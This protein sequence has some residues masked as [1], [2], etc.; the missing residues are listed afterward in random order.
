[1]QQ[2]WRPNSQVMARK[3]R[4]ASNLNRKGIAMKRF[5]MCSVVLFTCTSMLL[6]L[7]GCPFGQ[8]SKVA[9]LISAQMMPSETAAKAQAGHIGLE[10]IDSLI[11][12]VTEISFDRSRNRFRD[13]P[14][15]D[16]TD[17]D[18]ARNKVVVFTGA[19]D[20]ELRDLVGLAELISTTEVPVGRYTKIR[21]NIEDPRMILTTA[22]DVV[23][24]NI[25]TTGNGRLFVTARFEI[26]E[27]QDSLIIL[28]LQGLHLV[29]TG[30]NNYV[31]TPQLRADI[32]VTPVAVMVQGQIDSIDAEAKVLYLLSDSD[33]A[34]IPV[35][36]ADAA[37]Y[38]PEDADAPFGTDSDL[39]ENLPI[40]VEGRMAVTGEVTADI[41]WVL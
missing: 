1:M 15:E 22:P 39:V 19:V 38:L 7:S 6:L 29:E 24:T 36:F 21:L 8:K 34:I 37:I 30:N 41:I 3:L 2:P 28:D 13:E 26:P 10:D 35:G 12:T 40:V 11:V 31:W 25:Q 33:G 14:E 32:T 9:V 18:E 16:E 27:D 4:D 5:R 20:I 17:A 23:L